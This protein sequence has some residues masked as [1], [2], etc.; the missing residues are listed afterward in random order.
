MRPLSEQHIFDASHELLVAV[1]KPECD[2]R[3][4]SGVTEV[5]GLQRKALLLD[6]LKHGAQVLEVIV[7]G[8]LVAAAA[9]HTS[10]TLIRSIGLC[11]Y[12]RQNSS[13]ILSL[14][15]G[16]PWVFFG[17]A[18]SMQPFVVLRHMLSAPTPAYASSSPAATKACASAR[19]LCPSG[20]P[21][22][23]PRCPAL[24]RRRT[25]SQG[26]RTSWRFRTGTRSRSWP[27][28]RSPR[29]W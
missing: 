24:P 10:F 15:V 26:C 23:C 16:C 25:A 19:V 3:A 20:R 18:I 27:L 8:G 28:R 13:F 22:R 29:R 12:R 1:R 2:I 11:S 4:H 21:R 7:E 6:L 5:G 9:S 14:T 17:L